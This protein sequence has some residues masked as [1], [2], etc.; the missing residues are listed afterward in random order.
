MASCFPAVSPWV[1]FLAAMHRG[2]QEPHK[3]THNGEVSGTAPELEPQGWVWGSPPWA[4]V[5]LLSFLTRDVLSAD[6]Q[7]GAVLQITGQAEHPSILLKPTG[8]PRAQI[9]GKCPPL[10]HPKQ[11][12][13]LLVKAR[14]YF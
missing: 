5:K 8:A 1:V 14:G 13:E 2:H 6:H 4:A 3:P 7:P 9:K 11:L 12:E 10:A